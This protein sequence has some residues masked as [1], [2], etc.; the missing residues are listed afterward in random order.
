[1]RQPVGNAALPTH[2]AQHTHLLCR[3][4]SN[5]DV[6]AAAAHGQLPQASLH[7]RPHAGGGGPT[8]TAE[9]S[10]LP[11]QLSLNLLKMPL[12]FLLPGAAMDNE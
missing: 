11:P 12:P 6:K 2:S 1:M 9:L 4:P 10:G 3:P 8:A 7:R 5:L